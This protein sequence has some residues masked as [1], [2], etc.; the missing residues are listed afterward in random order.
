MDGWTEG[1][2]VPVKMDTLAAV[3]I[4][5]WKTSSSCA[6]TF[7]SSSDHHHLLLAL[8]LFPTMPPFP[9][10]PPP[11]ARNDDRT[12]C[13]QKVRLAKNH[14]HFKP[15]FFQNN[16]KLL[17]SQ[18]DEFIRTE[19]CTDCSSSTSLSREITRKW[20]NGSIQAH[21]QVCIYEIEERAGAAGSGEVEDGRVQA[22]T[23]IISCNDVVKRA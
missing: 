12:G 17:F 14:F 19:I 18:L 13:C 10:A 7:S 6:R 5:V 1:R 16:F 9:A 4:Q 11:K 8:Y 22:R 21:Y 15:T 2:A 23:P 20:N 3:F